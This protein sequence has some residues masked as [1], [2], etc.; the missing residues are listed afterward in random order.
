MTDKISKAQSSL[1]FWWA[2]SI[3]L[4]IF[5]C[6]FLGISVYT[7]NYYYDSS[8]EEITDNNKILNNIVS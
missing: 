6:V 5:S 1:N 4:L 3:C 2:I 7:Y 8:V